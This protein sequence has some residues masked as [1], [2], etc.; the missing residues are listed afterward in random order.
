MRPE[1]MQMILYYGLPAVLA[2]L[3]IC[4]LFLYKTSKRQKTDFNNIQSELAEAF[5]RMNTEWSQ[6]IYGQLG[7]SREALSRGIESIH[8]TLQTVGTSQSEHMERL[9]RHLSV[10]AREQE[11]RLDKLSH[12]VEENLKKYDIR[13]DAFVRILDEKLLANESRIEKMRDTLEAGLSGI[14][15]ENALKLEEMR[16]TVDE[17]LHET[18]DKRLS[19]SFS[20]VSQRLEQVY[21]GLGEMQNLANGVGDLKKVLSNVKTSGIWG[22]MQLGALLEQMLSPTQYDKNAAVNPGSQERVEYAVKFP[23]HNDEI[24]YLPIDSKFP[25]ESYARLMDALET[26]DREAIAA[27]R[28]DLYVRLTEEA[29]RISDKY[30]HAPQTTDFAVMFLPLEGLYAETMRDMSIAESLQ[31][32]FRV[33]IAG[34]STLTALLNSLQMGFRTLAIEKRSGEVWKLL[35]AVKTDFSRFSESLL[36]TQSRLRQ[37]TDQIDAT[38]IQTRKIEQKLRDVESIEGPVKQ[39]TLETQETP[40]G[41][42]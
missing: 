4:A 25:Q 31:R 23:G 12:T 41:L 1:T 28:K 5:R 6:M 18:L 7:D 26:A 35:S 16:K 42:P 40:P 32:R 39:M 19:D 38:F 29:K 27:C 30:I 33:V 24:V 22:E 17:K 15:T 3:L 20:Q 9:S 21:K 37:A 34:P 2:L 13:M 11:E 14:R 10:G 8:L 36:K